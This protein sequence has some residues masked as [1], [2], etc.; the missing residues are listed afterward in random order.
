MAEISS[1]KLF[2]LVTLTLTVVEHYI[3]LFVPENGMLASR[4][5]ILTRYQM[6]SMKKMGQLLNSTMYIQIQYRY[7]HC[8]TTFVWYSTHQC[9]Y[10]SDREEGECCGCGEHSHKETHEEAEEETQRYAHS[11]HI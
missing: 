7:I 1:S 5:E 2:F 11:Y 10:S 3:I 9:L 6:E 4:I 8:S